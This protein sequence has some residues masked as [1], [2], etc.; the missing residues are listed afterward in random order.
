MKKILTAIVLLTASLFAGAQSN[1][2]LVFGQVPT[3]AQWN[4]Y[5][6]AKTDYAAG[7]LAISK[8][9]TGATTAAGARANL[10]AGTVTTM[11]VTTANGFSGSVATATTTPA[12][13]I[14]P[15]NSDAVNVPAS[16]LLNSP[17]NPVE[18]TGQI[19]HIWSA[20][21]TD[22]ATIT[23]NGNGTVNIAASNTAIRGA[24][25]V[26]SITRTSTTATVTTSANHGFSTGDVIFIRGAVQTD[27]DG[28]FYITVTG[29]QTFTYTV[30]NSPATPATG[31]IYAVDTTGP[32][33]TAAVP[34]V[35]NLSLTDHVMNYV[36]VDWNAGSPQY[37]VLTDPTQFV[38]LARVGAWQVA[39]EGTT[40]W[41]TDLR[42]A[43][44]NS[45]N[46][47]DRMEQQTRSFG[48][49]LG[50]S[51]LS[52]IGTRNIALTAGS[53]WLGTNIIPH[54]AFDTSG[55]STFTTA[56]TSDGGST[57]TYTTGQTQI[58]NTQY[59][60]TASGLATLT[61]GNYGVHWVYLMNNEPSTLMVVYGQ[62]DYTKSAA[63]SSQEPTVKPAIVS[64]VGVLLGRI[65][66]LKSAS[67]FT[68]VTSNFNRPFPNPAPDLGSL[69]DVSV[70]SPAINDMLTWNGAL[71]VSAAGPTGSA[72][73]GAIFYNATPTITATGT[74]NVNQILTLSKTPVTTAEQT[75]TISLATNTV[76][77]SAW[78]YDTALGRSSID[79]GVWTFD[80]YAGVNSVAAGRVTTITRNVMQVIPGTG[81][82]ATTGS[83]TSRTAT[84]TAGTPFIAGDAS[85]TNTLASYLQT[86]QG[87]YQITAF[88]SSSAVTIATPTTYANETGVVY[89]NWRKLFGADS[90][91][92]TAISPAYA[93][94]IFS[95]TQAAFTI[96][97]TDKLGVITFGSSNNTTT[98]TTVYNGTTHNS[99]VKTPLSI[100]HDDISGLQGGTAGE[101]YHLT[102]A[103]YSGTGS[104]V[105]A[106]ATNPTLAGLTLSGTLTVSGQTISGATVFNAGVSGITT[107][108]A[109]GRVALNT[110]VTADGRLAIKQSSDA[111]Q[112]KGIT[113]EASGNDSYMGIGYDG[114][115]FVFSPTYTS[116]GAYKGIAF[117]TSNAQAMLIG[118]SGL[119]SMAAGY[120]VTGASTIT[121]TGTAGLRIAQAAAAGGNEPVLELYHSANYGGRWRVDN[122]AGD[123]HLDMNQGGSYTN[124]VIT[125]GAT[126]KLVT[127]SNGLTLS[128]GT[129]TAGAASL[130]TLGL[131]GAIT[132]TA[133]ANTF[134]T[135]GAATSSHNFR[136]FTDQNINFTTSGNAVLRT[137]DDA[138]TGYV[139]M[140]LAG[141]TVNILTFNGSTTGV[142]SSTGLAITGAISATTTVA[143]GSGTNIVYY[144]N[145]GTNVGLLGR[146]N[147]G[148]CSGGAWVA[149]SFK[150]D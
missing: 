112:Y 32:I 66:I 5:F 129:F 150:T 89:A 18:L 97:T 128:G 115:N 7:G 15:I 21:I 74:N 3:A 88:S 58:N 146:G 130:T 45:A 93:N 9:G 136:V 106:R 147:G 124:N 121:V 59:N 110:P 137:L 109:S 30:A 82:V 133:G 64:G 148:P 27:Y 85:A 51:I 72:G 25:A 22:G 60:N 135:P 113:L 71:W 35:T 41:M 99:D 34:A 127:M 123:L 13:T 1:P 91:A 36:V 111:N 75:A 33:Y 2:G 50:G 23:D 107:L 57:W 114:T 122:S 116:G 83:G 10:G 140:N 69:S 73:P 79:A 101:F 63:F 24:L 102:S 62:G 119:V 103:E 53:F 125:I 145:G 52:A 28:F 86:P 149:T 117:N 77:G 12:I 131:T 105:F 61:V 142:F 29:L 56:Y 20:G 126:T 81:T 141:L 78:L 42:G 90:A 47:T 138:G 70:A 144:C 4:S 54:A 19:D 49:T 16:R 139:A 94:N 37:I 143:A 104:G 48:Y 68:N 118:T 80:A 11:S 96:A 132:S 17:T 31:A 43:N 100:L 95:S 8:G 67:A 120:A 92:V 40:L 14:N 87:L 38:G 26:S 39:R 6:S 44:V 108:A 65:I 98:L 134:G 84:I 55:S 76:L 46:K